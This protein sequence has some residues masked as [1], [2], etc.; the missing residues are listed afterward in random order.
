MSYVS[1]VTHILTIPTGITVLSFI[2]CVAIR[3]YLHIICMGYIIILL[4]LTPLKNCDAI[5]LNYIST[6]NIL[7]NQCCIIN[8]LN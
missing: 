6:T 1:H 3:G 2:Q 5:D 4:N 7:C 8:F